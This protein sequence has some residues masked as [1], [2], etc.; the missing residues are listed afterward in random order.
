MHQPMQYHRHQSRYPADKVRVLLRVIW[1]EHREDV[2]DT[3]SDID[4][5]PGVLGRLA[6]LGTAPQEAVQELGRHAAPQCGDGFLIFSE[7]W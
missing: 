5:V 1:E 6:L 3:D 7:L 4:H 2:D